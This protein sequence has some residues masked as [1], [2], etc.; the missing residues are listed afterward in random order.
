MTN[1]YKDKEWLYQKYK[2]ERLTMREIAEL[3]GVSAPTITRWLKKHGMTGGWTPWTEER[4][5]RHSAIFLHKYAD[6]EMDHVSDSKRTPEVRA[7]MSESQREAW[8]EGK[9]TEERAHKISDSM[10]AYYKDTPGACKRVSE[11][12]RKRYEDPAERKKTGDASRAAHAKG[13]VWTIDKEEWRRRVSES[14]KRSY[15]ERPERRK[16]HS[17]IV[18]AAWERGAYDNKKLAPNR[19]TSIEILVSN[20]LDS[21]G[22]K[23]ISQFSPSKVRYTY[24]ELL[25]DLGILL[26]VHGDY[27]HSSDKQKARDNVKAELASELGYEYIVVWEHELKEQDPVSLVAEKIGNRDKVVSSPF[28]ALSLF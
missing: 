13:V 8:Q 21:L 9:Y 19:P 17:E 16:R 14:C 15:E 11:G 12:L 20:A 23:H 28:A 1:L 10:I 5:A 2:V 3:V 22:V 4:K 25:P 6:G 18:L 27:W 7:K 26:E 24:D